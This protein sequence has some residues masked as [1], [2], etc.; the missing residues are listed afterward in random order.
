MRDGDYFGTA[1]NR[2]AR[3]AAVAHG[4]QIVASAVTA[5]LVRDELAPDV[6]LVDLG[7]HRLRDLGRSE[8]IL[9]LAHP[10]LP[11]DFAPLRSLDAFPGNLPVCCPWSTT[12][13][14]LT[15]TYG[16]PVGNW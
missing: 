8:H 11:A 10:G 9:Q 15:I 6:T 7:E 13:T 1:V 4:E 5:D 14:P 3:V 2:A 12:T 16:I